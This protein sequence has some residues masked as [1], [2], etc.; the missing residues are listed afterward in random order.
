MHIERTD[1]FGQGFRASLDFLVLREVAQ[2][3]E[4]VK[5]GR[6][7]IRISHVWIYIAK[8]GVLLCQQE[9]KW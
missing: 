3:T 9:K 2:M 4:L 6:N 7:Q 5:Q 1:T 8:K